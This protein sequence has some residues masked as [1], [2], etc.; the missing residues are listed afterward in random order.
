[1]IARSPSGHSSIRSCGPLQ[2]GGTRRALAGCWPL[3]RTIR[4]LRKFQVDIISA[5]QTPSIAGITSLFIG[6]P[7]PCRKLGPH[8]LM[9]Q[10][11]QDGAAEYA[12]NG[13]DSA[14]GSAHPCP[15]IGVCASHCSTAG[16]TAAR[17][18]GVVH[19]AQR[20]DRHTPVGSNQSA[21][22]HIRFCQ[23]DRGDVGRSRMPM[24]RTRRRNTS[25]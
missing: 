12:A 10:S 16:M 6:Y 8:I 9:M 19:Q 24:A 25:P 11:A 15:R 22:P 7:C 3:A 2:P 23:G 1:M 20:R 14:G 4:L 17:D 5:S 18:A 13:L 21:V